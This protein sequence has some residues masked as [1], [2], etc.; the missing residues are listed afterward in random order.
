MK[1]LGVIPARMNSKRFP[2]KVIYPL[3]GKPLLYYLHTELKKSKVI[4]RLVI[5]TDDL[6][7]KKIAEGFGAEVI[8]TSKKHRT[9]SDRTAEVHRKLGGDIIIN[10]QA[11]NFGL[12]A[13]S[14]DLMLNRFIES[15]KLQFA[16]C[17]TKFSSNED[18]NNTNN[19]KA[20]LDKD[21]NAIY[22]SRYPIPF[23][24][25]VSEKNRIKQFT[26]FYH[27]GIYIYSAA[28][29][30]KFASWK[31]SKLEQ[32]ESLE[33]LRIIEH[34]EKIRIFETKMKPISVDSID[35]LKKIEKL[36]T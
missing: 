30:K 8:L 33:Q 1:V 7:I 34:G 16:T 27:I 25:D 13:R 31:P 6:E 14:I 28:G 4:D 22:F 21:S 20:I 24:R 17:A 9:G 5:A 29:L 11:D 26:F 35:E 18:L 36:Y 10:L 23:L 2:K 3:H 12:K 32:A 15:K 19:V